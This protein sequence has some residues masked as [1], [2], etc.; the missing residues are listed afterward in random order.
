DHPHEVVILVLQDYVDPF[1]VEASFER[2]RLIDY[3]YAIEPGTPLPTLREMIEL[4]RRILVLSEN[5]GSQEAPPWYADA[6][7]LVQDTP[8]SFKSVSEFV[9]RPFRGEA[10]SPLF[11]VNH[12][13]SRFPP[14]PDD[15]AGPNSYDVLYERARRCQ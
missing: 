10:A 4:D 2:T 15:A 5:L 11:M 9:C 3:V 1:D 6:F 7:T 14:S 8:F 12:W 13:I